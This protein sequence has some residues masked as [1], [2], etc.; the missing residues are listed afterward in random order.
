MNNTKNPNKNEDR[1]MENTAKIFEQVLRSLYGD[2]AS[3]D[4]VTLRL[5]EKENSA[6]QANNTPVSKH[7]RKV[8]ERIMRDMIVADFCQELT[9][10]MILLACAV[11]TME[12]VFSQV[13]DGA[14][15][16]RAAKSIFGDVS[17]MKNTVIQKWLD[18]FPEAL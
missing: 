2:R 18:F 9:N 5:S 1:E 8:R 16:V 13:F 11:E 10:D 17:E 3:V 15:P 14:M 4:L 6:H 7:A 12:N